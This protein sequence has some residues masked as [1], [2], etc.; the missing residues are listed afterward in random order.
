M[1]ESE[2][3]SSEG[4]EYGG[5]DLAVVLVVVAVA[6][7]EDVELGHVVGAQ[8]QGQPLVVGDVLAGESQLSALFTM[9]GE[10]LSHLI[11]S[12]NNL[13]GLLVESLV[14]PVRVEV[15]ELLGQSVV[16]PHPHSVE[17]SQTRLFVGARIP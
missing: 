5:V 10:A 2:G 17:H 7:G 13:P 14:V 12:D 9:R 6:H 3:S 4:V 16:F 15:A 8:H 11:L 1:S